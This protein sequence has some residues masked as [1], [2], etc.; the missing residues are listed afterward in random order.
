[1]VAV[2]AAVLLV[3]GYINFNA[4]ISIAADSSIKNRASVVV[5][6]AVLKAR[7]RLPHL[8]DILEIEKD[9]TGAITLLQIDGKLVNELSVN[10]VDAIQGE[11]AQMETVPVTIP[12]GNILL[13]Q[14]F[15]GL[16][17]DVSFYVY[18]VGSADVGFAYKFIDSGINQTLFQLQMTATMNVRARMGMFSYETQAVQSVP[19]CD[20]IVVGDV[21]ETYADV[22]D[23]ND[24][25]NLVP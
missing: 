14:F 1:M 16:G 19:I 5:N 22:N 25:L 17:P 13:S 4:N 24:F 10:I 18:P 9:E 21:P 2:A 11:L 6:R 7:E 23:I 15:S 20:I 12:L 8:A 3:M